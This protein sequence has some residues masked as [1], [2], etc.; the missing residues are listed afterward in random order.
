M[1]VFASVT[2]VMLI[3]Y[4][5]WKSQLAVVCVAAGAALAAGCAWL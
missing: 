4:Q 3:M 1:L 2:N 5:N